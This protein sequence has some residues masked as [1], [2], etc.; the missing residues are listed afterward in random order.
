MM[1][2]AFFIIFVYT[3]NQTLA[4][5][6]NPMTKAGVLL[7]LMVLIP[8]FTYICC[9]TDTEIDNGALGLSDSDTAESSILDHV[10]TEN[11]LAYIV[12]DEPS[13]YIAK[14]MDYEVATALDAVVDENVWMLKADSVKREKKEL[15]WDEWYPRVAIIKWTY[16]RGFK[17]KKVPAGTWLDIT[18]KKGKFKR[19]YKTTEEGW[20]CLRE[21]GASCKIILKKVTGDFYTKRNGRGRKKRE[22]RK[23]S[24]CT[25]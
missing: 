22:T 21:K 4:M 1:L 9:D 12:D 23:L 3:P 11:L 24:A 17:C 15:K 8:A 7:Y 6:S 10:D 16:M 2:S 25:P 20:W 13:I 14:G 18:N 19:S 5:F